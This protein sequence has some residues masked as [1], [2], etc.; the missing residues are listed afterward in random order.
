MNIEYWRTEIDEV[1]RELL[2]LLNR[3]ARLAIKVGT[4]KRV[5]GLPCCDPDREQVVLSNLQ[6][7]NTGPL[8]TRAITR[9]FRRIIWESRRVETQMTTPEAGERESGPREA[10]AISIESAHGVRG[11]EGIGNLEAL[12]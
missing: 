3:R 4:L 2:R 12:L 9:L 5:A 8:E 6:Q 11:L 10:E 7:S 1:D